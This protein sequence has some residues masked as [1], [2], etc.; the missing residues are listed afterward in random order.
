[1]DA[2][3]AQAEADALPPRLNRLDTVSSLAARAIASPI[4]GP[5]GMALILCTAAT[6]GVARIVSVTTSS[7]NLDFAMR[8]AA[9]PEST[10]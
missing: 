5:I 8:R 3:H 2:A 4:S 9:T 10:P 1:M 7:C 6:S